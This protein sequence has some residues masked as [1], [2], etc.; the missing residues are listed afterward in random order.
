MFEFFRAISFKKILLICLIFILIVII[1]TISCN[2]NIINRLAKTNSVN[3]IINSNVV[4][5]EYLN[6][7][8]NISTEELVEDLEKEKCGFH[9]NSNT[10][11]R[12]K[13]LNMRFKSFGNL[14]L[15][16]TYI[17]RYIDDVADTQFSTEFSRRF[18]EEILGEYGV[19]AQKQD[20]G[21]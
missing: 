16:L 4:G 1:A 15:I 9:N 17:P 2:T 18:G 19:E 13:S 10:K 14:P 3:S 8:S 7:M 11:D 6:Q 21:S 20:Y 12:F 5:A